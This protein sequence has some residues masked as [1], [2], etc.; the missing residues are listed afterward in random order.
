[1]KRDSLQIFFVLL[2]AGLFGHTDTT[3]STDF[4]DLNLNVDWGEVYR[5]AE[6]QGVVGLVAA[7]IEELRAENLELRVPQEVKLQFV[8]ATLQIEQRN[9][10]MNGFVAEL[11]ERMRK[12]GIYAVLVKGQGVA[13][14]Y[15]MPLWRLSGD[16]DLLLSGSNYQKAVDYL[17]PL[18][19]GSKPEGLYSKHLGIDIEDWYVELHGTL[20]TGLSARVDQEV[21]CV[22]KEVFYGGKVRSWMNGEIQVFLPGVD[23]DVLF[24]FTHYIKH[25]YKERILVKQLCD[26]CRLLWTYSEKV[27]VGLLAERLKRM[28]LMEEW[29]TYAAMAVEYLGMPVDSMPLYESKYEKKASRLMEIIFAG[30]KGNKMKEIWRIAKVFP[31][32]TVRFLPGIVLNI[33]T[34]KLREMIIK[35]D[36]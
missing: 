33:N 6:E 28:G 30:S 36:S 7:G 5:L 32:N 2:Q 13:Q 19:K 14:C 1:M 24:V 15:E 12:E 18:S 17:L 11:T 29:K 8:G 27:N 3:E 23:E 9:K 4:S 26:W 16:V 21:D 35:R 10:A 31:R 22:Q 34:L 25:F 20:R